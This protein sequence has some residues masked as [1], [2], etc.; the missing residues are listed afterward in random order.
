MQ[1]PSIYT[2]LFYL[3]TSQE[4]G[5]VSYLGETPAH[6]GM[7]G[8]YIYFSVY[9]G[10]AIFW[11]VGAWRC[12]GCGTECH[13][14][15]EPEMVAY[16]NQMPAVMELMACNSIS[17]VPTRVTAWCA[18]WRA[19]WPRTVCHFRALRGVAFEHVTHAALQAT[20]FFMTPRAYIRLA[21]CTFL[22]SALLAYWAVF[23]PGVWAPGWGLV[24]RP[25]LSSFSHAT[26]LCCHS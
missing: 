13:P 3:Q 4:S 2:L 8:F 7:S 26:L 22:T 25:L 23:L 5:L 19:S 20:A 10:G 15:S 14:T 17:P 21:C 6:L 12:L 16:A 11:Q 9:A 18:V 1:I 24:L